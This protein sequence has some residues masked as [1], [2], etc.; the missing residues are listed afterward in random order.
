[1]WSRAITLDHLCFIACSSGSRPPGSDAGVVENQRSGRDAS[2]QSFV[3]SELVIALRYCT[4]WWCDETALFLQWGLPARAW[5]VQATAASLRS[6]L[7][8]AAS[9]A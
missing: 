3:G 7:A 8:P 5:R 6:C 2:H 9:G 4:L 1:M